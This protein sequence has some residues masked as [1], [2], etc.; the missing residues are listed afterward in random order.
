MKEKELEATVKKAAEAEKEKCEKEGTEGTDDIVVVEP[1]TTEEPTTPSTD[2]GTP[3][4]DAKCKNYLCHKM[5]YLL[6]ALDYMGD[7]MKKEK[8]GGDDGD[9]SDGTDEE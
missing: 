4:Q 3:T 2:M 1:P 5:G 8:E 6:D 7:I 9:S